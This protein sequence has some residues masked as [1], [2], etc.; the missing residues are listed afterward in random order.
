MVHGH[1][2]AARWGCSARGAGPRASRRALSHRS[3]SSGRIGFSFNS[4]RFRLFVQVRLN[5][6]RSQG[7]QVC[8]GIEVAALRRSHFP[9]SLCGEDQHPQEL[10]VRPHAPGRGRARRGRPPG[11]SLRSEHKGR[12]LSVRRGD[13]GCRSPHRRHRSR[14]SPHRGTPTARSSRSC[15]SARA[16]WSTT[17]GRCSGSWT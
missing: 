4:D 17:S 11:A 8:C 6:S 16:P 3:S 12:C 15:S 1:R 10:M 2:S 7:E 5:D 9:I 14:A 13:Y